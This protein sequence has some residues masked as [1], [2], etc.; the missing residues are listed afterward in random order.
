M[1][2][3]P[4]RMRSSASS[5]AGSTASSTGWSGTPGGRG[6]LDPQDGPHAVRVEGTAVAHRSRGEQRDCIAH[7]TLDVGDVS[8]AERRLSEVP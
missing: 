4:D 2:A 1:A 8:Q 3:A 6:P 7:V 5:R